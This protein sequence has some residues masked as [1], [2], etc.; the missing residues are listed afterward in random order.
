MTPTRTSTSPPLV[1]AMSAVATV[2]ALATVPSS[3]A[4]LSAP[5]PSTPTPSSFR[6][7]SRRPTFLGLRG[8]GVSEEEESAMDR[9]ISRR[10]RI[11]QSHNGQPRSSMSQEGSAESLPSSQASSLSSSFA[12]EMKRREELRG[13]LE[14]L[15]SDSEE[16]ASSSS[17]TSSGSTRDPDELCHILLLGS[18]FTQSPQQMSDTF[19]ASSCLDVLPPGDLSPTAARDAVSFAKYEGM[20]RLG[21]YTREECLRYGSELQERCGDF[22]CRVVPFT[23]TVTGIAAITADGAGLSL[24]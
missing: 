20:S 15:C 9:L 16:S 2:L 1:L 6:N 5:T 8:G 4:L 22:R 17:M 7:I 13:G 3:H 11:T 23:T 19:A 21:T 18:T 24:N 10:K 14:Y 12:D